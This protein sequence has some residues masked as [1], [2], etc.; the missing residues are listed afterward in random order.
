MHADLVA[1]LV[2]LAVQRAE[3]AKRDAPEILASAREG[4][5]SY[6]HLGN[7]MFLQSAYFLGFMHHF[8]HPENTLQGQ[9]WCAEL[10]Q[11]FTD[12]LPRYLRAEREKGEK[13]VT[14]EWS[15]LGTLELLNLFKPEGQ[16]KADWM[17]FLESYIE[18]ACERPF[19]FTSPNHEAWREVFLYR[20]GV[21][22]KRPELSELALF[23]CKQELK[24]QTPEGFWE[25]GRHHGPSMSYNTIMLE[26]LAWLYRFS[27]DEEIGN[28]ARRLAD[29]MAGW[30]FPD[31]CT[32][33]AFDGRQTTSFGFGLPVCPGLELTPAGRTLTARGMELFDRRGLLEASG[34]GSAW[35]D[36]FGLFFVGMALR[37]YAEEVPTS[38]PVTEGSS[39][40]LPVDVDG[41]RENHSPTFDGLLSR[42]GAW[43][44]GL[45]SQN[46]EIARQTASIF[47]LERSSR[48]ELW[49]KD[50][51]L[52][53][54]GG[55]NRRDWPVP[56]ANAILDTGFAGET[57]FG[58]VDQE[59]NTKRRSYYLSHWNESRCPEGHPELTLH[60][61][62]GSVRWRFEFAGDTEVRIEAH[63][64]VREVKR[65]SL[66]L[67]L[68]VWRG[69]NLLLDGA[70]AASDSPSP[71]TKTVTASGGPFGSRVELT[72][73][74]GAAA[75]VHYPLCP[76]KYYID[77]VKP[78]EGQP[79]CS[80]ALA[81]CQWTNPAKTGNATWSL[82]VGKA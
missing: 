21:V 58:R 67:P 69:A 41:T 47:R 31:G 20:A 49:H 54:G 25:E 37:Y 11:E 66:Q 50:A 74:E 4:K 80:M 63:W 16:R 56:Y 10:A 33:G 15:P 55:H 3:I 65:L 29:F 71:V 52:V 26:P 64:D 61:A 62:H 59:Q 9:A 44:L 73:P 45:S 82:R 28:G 36:H 30:C 14:A 18:F 2:R 60:F 77:P 8:K 75:R 79:L 34:R 13:A 35:Y 53:L 1:K 68:V 72:L 42:K 27:G 57:S 38:E 23:F 7:Y 39:G 76:L 81:A 70:P 48:I 22:L 5:N 46:S 78:D 19:G 32:V 12:F 24:Y 40:R 6:G 51:R 43:C 17:E